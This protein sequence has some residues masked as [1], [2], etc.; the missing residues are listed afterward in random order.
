MRVS[1][2]IA[3]C[4]CGFFMLS[5]GS[6]TQELSRIQDSA[7]ASNN[8][9]AASGNPGNTGTPAV[10]APTPASAVWARTVSVA[11][12]D[13]S[14]N[15]VAIDTSGNIYAAG[16]QFGTGTYTFGSQSTN[17]SNA[18]NNSALVKYDAVG[19]VQWARTVQASA[20][21]SVFKAVAVDTTGNIYAAGFQNNSSTF[22]YTAGITATGN[23]AG[24]N[25]ALVKYN[26][27]GTGVWA[28]TVA[29]CGSAAQANAVATDASGNVYVAGF[30]VGTATYGYGGQNATGTSTFNNVVVVKYNPSGTPL[31]ARSLAGGSNNAQFNALAVD[32]TGN[33]YAAG[34]QSG[35]GTY[36]YGSQAATATAGGTNAVLVKYDSAGTALWAT[37]V[38]AGAAASQFLALATDLS[39]NVFA[40]GFQTGTGSF[41]YG[42]QS[43]TGGSPG[44]NITLVKYNAAGTV[45]AATTLASGSGNS[46]FNSVAIDLSGNIFAAGFQAG[47][48]P[49][50]F[51]SASAT[52][53]A[54]TNNPILVKYNASLSA[55][56]VNT[57]AAGTTSAAFNA[58]A[59]DS[60][61]S[62]YAAGAQSGNGTYTYGS[63]S[64]AGPYT[65]NNVALVKYQ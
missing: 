6:L 52:G 20:G 60:S 40:V 49:Y 4:A 55:Q 46:Q 51:G 19:N 18:G 62:L 37:T 24:N 54:T 39:G 10:V 3:L 28:R 45:L 41:T 15:G 16:S 9:A 5:C 22:T 42:G 11:P 50:T 58:I 32:N 35:A 56:W 38:S 31:W 2:R 47:T 30:Q 43:I 21:N 26:S 14:F 36:T 25:L 65:G 29:A 59:V 53:T 7:S 13:S 17:G 57:I 48:G 27:T 12:T 8:P 64:I 61:N 23:C 34:Y 44:T 63:Q 33:V 1:F